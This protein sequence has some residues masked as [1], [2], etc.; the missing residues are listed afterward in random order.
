MSTKVFEYNKGK[1]P[2]RGKSVVKQKVQTCSLKF[3]C[4]AS[5]GFCKPPI[6]VKERTI[7]ANAG[8]GD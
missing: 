1:Q 6:S 5:V 4:L 8:L 7:L 3:V 2:R